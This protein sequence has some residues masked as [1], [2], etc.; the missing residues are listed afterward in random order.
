MTLKEITD[1]PFALPPEILHI[2]ERNAKPASFK[3]NEPIIRSGD[4]DVA[5]YFIKSGIARIFYRHPASPSGR[6]MEQNILFGKA[7][8]LATSLT[9]FILGKPT[10]LDVA[11]VT[12]TSAYVVDA[13]VIRRLYEESHQFC[14][15]LMELSLIQ[16]AYL[17]IR[18][19]YLAPRDAYQR[20]LS[21][22]RFKPKSFMR[23]VPAYHIAS[24][25]NITPTALSL[26]RARYAKDVIKME[27]DKDFLDEVGITGNTA[28]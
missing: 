20:F 6:H 14:R 22:I 3:R 1:T 5:F 15:W 17:E 19:T 28:E 16:L 11:A 9:D 12:G 13:P 23:R 18:H 8:D 10:V 7:G 27:Y 25:L 26:I 2:L 21:F 4:T 24:Y